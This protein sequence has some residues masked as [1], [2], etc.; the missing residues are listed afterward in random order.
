MTS[1][2]EQSTSSASTSVTDSPARARSRSPSNP[3]IRATLVRRPEGTI[4]TVSPG[5]T[6]PLAISPAKPRK[7]E[8]GR[9]THC[10]GRRNGPAAAASAFTSTVSRCSTSVGPSCQ[11][12]ASDR[13]VTFAPVSP[14]SGIAVAAPIPASPANAAPVGDDR[15]EHRLRSCPT[16]SIL[17]TAS[18]RC[19]TPSRWTS[20]LCRRV[21]VST[22]LRASIRMTAR[23]AVD[24]P[25]T[26]LRVYCSCPGVSATMK[27]R[28][29]GR[30]IAIG[31][32][33]RDAL[34]ALGGEPVD[35]QREVER[36]ALC[37][38]APRVGGELLNL[39]GKH[40]FGII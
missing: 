22:P 16:R 24:A 12:I 23:S 33:D 7:S 15:V 9:L 35:Q 31:D 29:A 8:S 30:E 13:V 32:V 17:L 26:M 20:Q 28:R 19:R 14:D 40:R 36:G 21:C 39:I 10:T 11:G 2:R 5:R 3:A 18:T 38:D 27:R 25:V 37:P 1:P 34:L 4:R 6:V